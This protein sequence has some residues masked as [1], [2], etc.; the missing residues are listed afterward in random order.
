[1]KPQTCTTEKYLYCSHFIICWGKQLIKIESICHHFVGNMVEHE[2]D[3][4]EVTGGRRTADT[5]GWRWVLFWGQN[6]AVG[7]LCLTVTQ[8]VGLVL[9]PIF[10]PGRTFKA[11]AGTSIK[12]LFID[13]LA[14]SQ[15]RRWQWLWATEEKQQQNTEISIKKWNECDSDTHDTNQS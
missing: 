12:N 3:T 9:Q 10:N 5:W 14:F 11:C 7:A 2:A 4:C 8:N 1:M 15:N 6:P 13:F